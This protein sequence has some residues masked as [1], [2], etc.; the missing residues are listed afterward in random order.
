MLQALRAKT[1]GLIAKIV[2]GLIVIAFSFFGIESYFISQTDS[3]VARVGDREI[4]QQDFRSRFDEYRQQKLQEA[5]GQIDARLFEQPAIKLQFLEKLID[6]EVLLAAN[7]RL[8]AIIPADRLRNEIARIPA[9]QSNGASDA[10]LYRARLSSTG[11]APVQFADAVAREPA[12]R[13]LPVAIAG[14]A[15]VTER[16]VDDFLRLRGQLRDF[17]YVTLGGP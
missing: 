15:F 9:F 5:Q 10:S 3:F 1:T 2:L 16:E 4:S 13:E 7:E 14:T 17:R 11:R 8:G 6:D 12:A